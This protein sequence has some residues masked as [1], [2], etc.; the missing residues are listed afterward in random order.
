MSLE[1]HLGRLKALLSEEDLQKFEALSHRLS[2]TEGDFSLL[3]ESELELIAEMERK[4]GDQI[5][6]TA[7]NHASDVVAETNPD[8]SETES[9]G[10]AKETI[11]DTINEN[12]VVLDEF[13]LLKTEFAQYVKDMLLREL[14]SQFPD[15]KSSVSYAFENKWIPQELR[16]QDVCETL[17]ERFFSDIE[18]ANEW[19]YQLNGQRTES[20][21]K[22]MAI[23][24]TWFM[25]IFQLKQWIEKLTVE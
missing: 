15:L 5:H 14:G 25:Y 4:Y 3:N 19:R 16:N 1:N 10:N 7:V 13:P 21:N 18:K 9:E 2:E 17:Y 12:A 8:F 24:L 11:R 20:D 6:A 22:T 23:G